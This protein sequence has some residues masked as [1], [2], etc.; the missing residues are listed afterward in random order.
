MLHRRHTAA[1]PDGTII[2]VS[3]M[4]TIE[5]DMVQCVHCGCQWTIQPG[6]GKRR[7][8]CTYH[9]GPTCGKPN[10]DSCLRNERG[11]QIVPETNR[12]YLR[13]RRKAGVDALQRMKAIREIIVP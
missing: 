1:R 12:A 6:S 11:M 8:F 9:M 13:E 10:C 2:V 3:D 7:N 4:G 5:R